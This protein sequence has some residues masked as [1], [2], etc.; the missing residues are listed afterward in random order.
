MTLKMDFTKEE[1]EMIKEKAMLNDEL[2]KIFEMKIKG[3]S[4]TEIAFKLNLSDRTF[5]RRLK[6]LKKKIM[7][8]I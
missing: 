7:E 1:F 8:V 6:K 2:T 3:Y 4:N 5:D